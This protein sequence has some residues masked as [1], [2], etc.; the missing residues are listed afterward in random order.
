MA[1][2]RQLPT[3]FRSW[4]SMTVWSTSAG[5]AV[6]L[7]KIDPA[8]LVVGGFVETALPLSP[9]GHMSPN[10]QLKVLSEPSSA[11][12]QAREMP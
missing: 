7:E 6:V 5:R 2:V 1:P 12:L 9:E 4:P 11:V 8:E 3:D 10:L